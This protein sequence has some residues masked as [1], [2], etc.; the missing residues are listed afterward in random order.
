[1]QEIHLD[2]NVRLLDC[3]GIVFDEATDGV[4]VTLR[5][6]IKVE[7]IAA[8]EASVEA[9][10][11]RCKKSQLITIYKIATFND[12]M[13]FLANVARKQGKLTKVLSIDSLLIHCYCCYLTLSLSLSLSLL[14][15]G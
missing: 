12:H 4:E 2:K 10:L 8:P 13:E 3:P 9:I 11:K 7:K 5:N 14:Y 1:M 15:A 6:C